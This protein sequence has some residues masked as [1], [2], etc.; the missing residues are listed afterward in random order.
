M[1]PTIL[2]VDDDSGIRSFLCEL[3][4]DEGYDALGLEDGIVAWEWL[5]TTGNPPQLILLDLMMPIMTGWEFR[6]RQI[7]DSYLAVI[8]VIVIS[9]VADRGTTV[10]LDVAATLPKPVPIDQLLDLV[11]QHITSAA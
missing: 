10:R 3:L 11:A 9:A 5:H 6:Q 8:P 1:P 7:T 2:I 4:R